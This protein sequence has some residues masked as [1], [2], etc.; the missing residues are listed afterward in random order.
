MTKLLKRLLGDVLLDTELSDVFSSFDII[1]N[2]AV[3]KIPDCL[4]IKKKLIGDT[5]LSN[6]SNLKTVLLQKTAVDGEY[7]LRGLELI[8]G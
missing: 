6:V 8:A 4:L 3:I 5:L 2:I 1:G 7:R